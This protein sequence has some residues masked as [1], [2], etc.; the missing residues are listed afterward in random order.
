MQYAIFFAGSGQN[1]SSDKYVYKDWA[2]RLRGA[3]YET[4]VLD[5]VGEYSTSKWQAF[6]NKV[7]F[8]SITGAG[9]ANIVSMRCRG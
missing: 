7:S 5:G 6:K 4:L 3:H 2:E 9:W 1:A 8:S